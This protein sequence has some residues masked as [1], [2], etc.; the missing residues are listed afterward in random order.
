MNNEEFPVGSFIVHMRPTDNFMVGPSEW[1][2]LWHCNSQHETLG[3]TYGKSSDHRTLWQFQ[4][5]HVNDSRTG[6][7]GDHNNCFGH[8]R[9]STFCPLETQ[10][11]HIVGQKSMSSSLISELTR[12]AVTN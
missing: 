3:H 9:V 11:R 1:F 2:S 6:I 12:Y 7:L 10:R 8:F 4:F 5:V